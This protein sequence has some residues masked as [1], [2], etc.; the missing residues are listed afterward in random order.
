MSIGSLSAFGV[1]LAGLLGLTVCLW[2]PQAKLPVSSAPEAECLISP[3][4]HFSRAMTI[5]LKQEARNAEYSRKHDSPARQAKIA[6]GYNLIAR[7]STPD[8]FAATHLPTTIT[9]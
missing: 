6:A 7:E 3:N 1:P 8:V 9:P 4:P 2:H 5:F